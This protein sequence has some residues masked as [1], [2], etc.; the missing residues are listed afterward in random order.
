MDSK[1]AI[2]FLER[3][4][5]ISDTWQWQL[6]VITIGVDV[7]GQWWPD[8]EHLLHR[9]SVCAKKSEIQATR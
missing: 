2:V 6:G 1:H 3:G 5:D 4:Y 7:D 8:I 9:S